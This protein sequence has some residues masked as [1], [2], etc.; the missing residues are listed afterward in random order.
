MSEIY[1]KKTRIFLVTVY[2]YT[3]LLCIINRFIHLA[4]GPIFV[5]F[6]TISFSRKTFGQ[7]I[8]QKLE[9]FGYNLIPIK[10]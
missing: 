2:I 7:I 1:L 9:R 4:F 10:S 6:S 8:K 5:T 3:I